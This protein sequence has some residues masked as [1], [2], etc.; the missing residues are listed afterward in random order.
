MVIKTYVSESMVYRTA[1][2]LDLALEGIDPSKEDAG[3]KTAKAL[4]EY[5]LECSI[6]KNFGSE[7]LDYVADECVQIMG[8]YGY[9]QDNPVEC[10]YRDSR[11]NR[12]WEGTNEINRL[13]IVD[14]LMRAAM[15]GELP[16]LQVIKKVA[17]GLL[18]YKPEMGVEEEVLEKERKMVAMAKKIGLL[19][20]GAAVQKYMDRLGDDAATQVYINDSFPQV[21]MMAR[22]VFA[23]VSEGEELRTQLM[24][25]KK[26]ARFAPINTIALRRE[27]ADSIIPAA[28]YNLTQA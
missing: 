21:D 17:G 7:M 9:I 6:N 28:R 5:A 16:L 20:A 2:L 24:G 11:I 23:A 19:A 13:L 1:G 18:S 25:L 15:K 3:Q 14:T 12:I 22:Q 10:A 4:R 27:V 26:L 8:G